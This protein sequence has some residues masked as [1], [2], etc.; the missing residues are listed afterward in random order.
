MPPP[1]PQKFNIPTPKCSFT[2]QTTSNHNIKMTPT[3]IKQYCEWVN[4]NIIEAHSTIQE[5]SL[6]QQ[7]TNV[8]PR[9]TACAAAGYT[10][11]AIPDLITYLLAAAGYP[12][13]QTWIRAIRQGHYIGWPGLMAER[14]HKFLTP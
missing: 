5:A 9:H 10:P 2:R 12:V 11:K 1:R 6:V 13:K 7:E 14:F 8:I 3:E 4:G